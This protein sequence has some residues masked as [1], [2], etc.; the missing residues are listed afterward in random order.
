MLV[1]VAFMAVVISFINQMNLMFGPGILIP[2]ILGR[3]RTPK[4]EERFFMFLDLKSSVTHA[5]DLGH[6]EYSSLIR[7]CFMD[8]NKP[9][10][11]N[12]AEIYQ[13]VGDEAVITWPLR[14][15]IRNLSCLNLYYDFKKELVRKRSYYLHHYG[16]VPE[17]KAGLH[18][19]IVTA[20]EVGQIK[21][22]IAYHGDAIN[23]AARVQSLCNQYD[24][25]FLI[26]KAVETILSITNSDYNFEYLGETFLKGKAQAIELYGIVDK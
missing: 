5:E 17:F 19:G 12:N 22:E 6:L 2:L 8:L 3:Y 24:R 1:Y 18:F 10:T 11:L 4:E 14:E 7:D 23:T 16:L 13:Y 26:P 21:R 9:L 25:A 20:V 15:G